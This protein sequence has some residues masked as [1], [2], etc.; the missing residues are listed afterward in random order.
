MRE[1]EFAPGNMLAFGGLMLLGLPWLLLCFVVYSVMEGSSGRT[2][3]KLLLGIRVVGTDLK[4]CGFGRALVRNLLK[5]VDGFFSWLVGLLL[6]ALTDD[7]QR[8]GDMA[9]R[10]IVVRIA[11]EQE[12]IG[13]DAAAPP[14]D[15]RFRT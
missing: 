8:L 4:P 10:T 14:V 1:G 6:V 5:I 15:P 9:A 2:P 13:G 3:G 7:W 11:G 12:P